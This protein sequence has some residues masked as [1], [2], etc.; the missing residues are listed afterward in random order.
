MHIWCK[1]H[2]IF[3]VH[4]VRTI[5]PVIRSYCS[6]FCQPFRTLT[7]DLNILFPC[8][9]HR[10]IDS[11]RISLWLIILKSDWMF[12]LIFIFIVYTIMLSSLG[13]FF[14]IGFRWR[15]KIIWHFPFNIIF[16]S[17]VQKKSSGS[18]WKFQMLLINI[19]LFQFKRFYLWI[20]SLSSLEL[21]SWKL[22]IMIFQ[23]RVWVFD[24]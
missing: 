10:F 22:S 24:L 13:C 15:R 21:R 14:L 4:L 23:Y 9:L 20:W 3:L 8:L 7:Y 16:R 11:R 2:R 17:N 1:W 19:D 6:G 12:L 18:S 5:T